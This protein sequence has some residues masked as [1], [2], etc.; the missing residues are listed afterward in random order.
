MN[1]NNNDKDFCSGIGY[2]TPRFTF[3]LQASAQ[4]FRILATS[5]NYFTTFLFSSICPN[6]ERTFLLPS[7]VFVNEKEGMIFISSR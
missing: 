5:H 1:N 2:Y 7:I 6:C 4:K 3:L